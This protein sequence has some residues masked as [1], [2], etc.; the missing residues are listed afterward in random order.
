MMTSELQISEPP[1]KSAALRMKH[2]PCS[3]EQKVSERGK[4]ANSPRFAA[5]TATVEMQ[6]CVKAPTQLASKQCVERVHVLE[7]HK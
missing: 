5:R 7:R 6:D 4:G 1:L 2:K 3:T